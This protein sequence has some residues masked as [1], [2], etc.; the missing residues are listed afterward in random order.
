MALAYKKMKSPIY[1]LEKHIKDS[2]YKIAPENE[3][4]L[5]S[6]CKENNF[7]IEL[8]EK[9]GFNFNVSIKNKKVKLPVAALEYL[10]AATHTYLV[11]YDEYSTAQKKGAKLYDTGGSSSRHPSIEI[12]FYQTMGVIKRAILFYFPYNSSHSRRI[13]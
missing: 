7:K 12:Y 8:V 5:D 4:E 6:W 11:L 2:V 10:W 13:T 9:N 3:I 1:S